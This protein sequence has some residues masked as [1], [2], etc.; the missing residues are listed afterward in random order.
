MV[1]HRVFW[2]KN[3]QEKFLGDA[4]E[5]IGAMMNTQ[6][7]ARSQSQLGSWIPLGSL[8]LRLMMSSGSDPP[9]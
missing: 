9:D 3:G 8:G 7:E 2:P 6:V 4:K 1:W 5:A